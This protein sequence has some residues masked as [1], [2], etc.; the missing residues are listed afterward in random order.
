MEYASAPLVE[1][2][3]YLIKPKKSKDAT[4][5][6][7]KR[8]AEQHEVYDKRV[9]ALEK[10]RAVRQANLAAKARDKQLAEEAARKAISMKQPD[11]VIESSAPKTQIVEPI[12][13]K[14]M[15]FVAEADERADREI[16]DMEPEENADV[17]GGEANEHTYAKVDGS[18]VYRKRLEIKHPILD[19]DTID[20]GYDEGNT[21]QYYKG[22]QETNLR[23]YL[24]HPTTS[25]SEYK[26]LPD[27]GSPFEYGEGVIEMYTDMIVNSKPMAEK[28][29]ESVGLELSKYQSRV[30][31]P[32]T[33]AYLD[34]T[35]MRAPSVNPAPPI[36]SY[37]RDLFSGNPSYGTAG[38]F[39]PAFTAVAPELRSSFI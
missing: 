8:T 25:S 18:T 32:G 30:T 31:E 2:K 7:I 23:K 4:T 11:K 28:I 29:R 9:R 14:T 21:F 20:S 27:V 19:M 13:E 33:D 15:N 34:Y 26:V 10:A 22:V 5:T 36:E 16:M 24:Q 1:D 6:S 3:H 38:N 39:R 12:D 35:A 37:T 17:G